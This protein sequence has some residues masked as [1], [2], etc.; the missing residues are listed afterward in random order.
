MAAEATA[1]LATLRPNVSREMSV[2]IDSLKSGARLEPERGGTELDYSVVIVPDIREIRKAPA[3]SAYFLSTLTST[4][5]SLGI[6]CTDE[7]ERVWDAFIG[8]IKNVANCPIGGCY[9]CEDFTLKFSRR[10][11]TAAR[12][13]C[14]DRIVGI[15]LDIELQ[16]QYLIESLPPIREV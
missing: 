7:L 5:P 13:R 2:L 12:T 4:C 14:A 16:R 9:L 11:T 8:L 6:L 1:P 15:L 3:G 10:V